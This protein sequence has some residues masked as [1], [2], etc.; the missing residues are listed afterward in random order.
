[1]RTTLG[2]K[3]ASAFSHF[4]RNLLRSV[5]TGSHDGLIKSLSL[6]LV[7]FLRWWCSSPIIQYPVMY[8]LRDRDR[9]SFDQFSLNFKNIKL[10]E[11]FIVKRLSAYELMAKLI[12][13]I[14]TCTHTNSP[15]H[16]KTSLIQR[17]S[18]TGISHE[19]RD[20]DCIFFIFHF[21]K[22]PD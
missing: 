19:N 17:A 2:L 6:N 1:M 22:V 3:K 13:M 5:G 20:H 7:H 15:I 21:K 18:N 11:L 16:P 14:T 12:T 8:F 4:G 9:Y 10:I